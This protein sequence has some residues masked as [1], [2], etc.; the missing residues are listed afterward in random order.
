MPGIDSGFTLWLT[1]LSGSGKTTIAELVESQ[2]RGQGR[3]VE[4]LDGEV[5]RKALSNTLG[6]SK[7][8][9][10]YH[11]RQLGL[12][13]NLLSRNGIVAIVA[14]ISPYR[15]IRDE[16]RRWHGER[17]IEVFLSCPVQTL[18]DRDKRDLYRRALAGDLKN[19]TGI[20]DPY[21]EPLNPELILTT[22][23]EEANVSARKI[24]DWLIEHQYVPA[25]VSAASMDGRGR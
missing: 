21:E 24:W 20:S 7:H 1:G 14:A 16:V 22:D 15:D 6:F 9:R 23:R 3:K 25:L 13:S 2:L 19:F 12:A 8:D 5:I 11:V 4:V 18:I 10:D 17:F